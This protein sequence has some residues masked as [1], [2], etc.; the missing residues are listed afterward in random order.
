M[1][2]PA[3]ALQNYLRVW[4]PMRALE[5]PREGGERDRRYRTK[6]RGLFSVRDV[7]EKTERRRTQARQVLECRAPD[8]IWKELSL[9]CGLEK[10]PGGIA[11][12]LETF[13]SA[14]RSTGHVRDELILGGF[15]R[16]TVTLNCGLHSCYS[17]HCNAIC[18]LSRTPS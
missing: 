4:G 11:E 1:L 9:G 8:D 17:G 15:S 16:T 3:N 18:L 7:T 14:S 12:F 6:C 10:A 2:V 13:E 5:C